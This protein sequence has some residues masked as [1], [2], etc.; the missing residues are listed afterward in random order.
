MSRQ[1]LMVDGAQATGLGHCGSVFVTTASYR[2]TDSVQQSQRPLA[3][4]LGSLYEF[5]WVLVS[6]RLQM[7]QS[8]PCWNTAV[9]SIVPW[10]RVSSAAPVATDSQML[11]HGAMISLKWTQQNYSVDWPYSVCCLV[12]IVAACD[13]EVRAVEVAMVRPG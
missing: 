7:R 13:V 6:V 9:H 2:S 3:F 10:Q 1:P 8:L 11:R 4:H 5:S 12:R